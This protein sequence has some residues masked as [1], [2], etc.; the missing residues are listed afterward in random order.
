METTIVTILGKTVANIAKC[1]GLLIL[2]SVV[3]N[4]LRNRT[5][6]ATKY[7]AQAFRF[8]TSRL[9]RKAA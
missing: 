3:S 8:T 6:D 5:N 2:S 4:Q 1:A 7:L 9:Q